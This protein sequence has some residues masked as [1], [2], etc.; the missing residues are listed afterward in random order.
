MANYGKPTL[1]ITETVVSVDSTKSREA[2]LFTHLASPK[3]SL[4]SFV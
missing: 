3:K 2:W 4:E 1:R